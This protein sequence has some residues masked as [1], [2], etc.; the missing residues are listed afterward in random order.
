MEEQENTIQE[1]KCLVAEAM[2]LTQNSWKNTKG[3]SILTASSVGPSFKSIETART[4]HLAAPQQIRANEYSARRL[5]SAMTA[6]MSLFTLLVRK[7]QG[8]CHE[9][10]T[11]Q[12]I[13]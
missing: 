11:H 12:I 7:I 9:Q 4:C 8:G 6:M 1:R 13:T 3:S 10:T 2:M 5:V